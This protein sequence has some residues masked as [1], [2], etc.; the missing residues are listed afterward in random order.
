MEKKEPSEVKNKLSVQI[1]EDETYWTDEVKKLAKVIRNLED[2]PLGQVNL[3]STMAR[4]D[5]YRMRFI[6][7]YD[8]RNIKF[9]KLK[10]DKIKE[11][12]DSPYKYNAKEK[13][14][15]IYGDLA[16]EYAL[17]DLLT[18]HIEFLARKYQ[19]LLQITYAVKNRI[20]LE[21]YH[22]TGLTTDDD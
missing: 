15:I 9:R 19:A 20:E 4:L 21:K 10:A 1:I 16:D 14:D 18:A 7:I 22:R 3:H 11:V 6:N 2:I 8:K 17:L 12:W 13:E 5:D